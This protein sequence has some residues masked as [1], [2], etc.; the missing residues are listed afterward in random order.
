MHSNNAFFF[1]LCVSVTNWNA[2]DTELKKC[3]LSRN[4]LSRPEKQRKCNWKKSTAKNIS[5]EDAAAGNAANC[6]S[7]TE[8]RP[9]VQPTAREI[10]QVTQPAM[11][12]TTHE[13]DARPPAVQPAAREAKIISLEDAAASSAASC[14]SKITELPAAQPAAREI[15]QV[16]Q[17]AV[18]P[19]AHTHAVSKTC[20]EGIVCVLRLA[21]AKCQWGI[22]NVP[23][24]SL[25]RVLLEKQ[26]QNTGVPPS[27][28]CR[29]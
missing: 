25:S 23:G 3:M 24:I 10:M 22:Q 21:A 11:Q 17:P 12:P 18:R 13:C 20:A 14:A 2:S 26:N 29:H 19:A 27:I 15:L 5:L 6:A 7:K 1:F 16:T 4:V 9:A 28:P 8:E